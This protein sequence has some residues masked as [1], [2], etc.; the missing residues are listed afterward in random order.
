MPWRRGNVHSMTGFGQAEKSFSDFEMTLSIRTLNSR[1][2]DINCRLPLEFAPLER[3]IRQAVGKQLKRGRIEISIT[4]ISHQ[5][6]RYELDAALIED[7][8]E[9]ARQ[10]RRRGVPGQ[11]DISTLLQLPN[12]MTLRQ[13]DSSPSQLDGTAHEVLKQAL[14]QVVESRRAEGEALKQQ[15]ESRTTTLKFILQEIETYTEQD[16]EHHKARLQKRLRL[17]VVDP[18]VAADRLARE[19]VFYVGRSDIAEEL[20][21]L[22]VHLE[23][24]DEQ[25][26]QSDDRSV[27]RSMDF[28][29]QELNREMNTILSKA[30]MASISAAA[31]QGKIEIEKLRELV[32]NVE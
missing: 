4:L 2:L 6:E 32:Q 27:G 12:V 15:I 18:S 24:F 8:L 7:Y 16:A 14:D 9:I 3:Q 13:S 25:C 20:T 30:S 19:V 23:R 26:S 5:K 28:L 21:R 31:L 17:W 22:G 1:Y 11:L 29:C 10:I